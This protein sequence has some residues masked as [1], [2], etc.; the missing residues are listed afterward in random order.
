MNPRV[1]S[2]AP[3]AAALDAPGDDL[4]DDREDHQ[5]D[6]EDRD[7]CGHVSDQHGVRY[8]VA[9]D[10][11]CMGKGEKGRDARTHPGSDAENL[12]RSSSAE[13]EQRREDNDQRHQD[14]DQI[15]RQVFHSASI[16]SARAPPLGEGAPPGLAHG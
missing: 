1:R 13:G 11:A 4:V 16:V 7:A 14:V 2:S 8:Q 12:P 3:A 10:G 15:D 5:H 6:D 9:G